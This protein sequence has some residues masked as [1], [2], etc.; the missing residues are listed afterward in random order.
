RKSSPDSGAFKWETARQAVLESMRLAL[1]VDS[2]RLWRQGIPDRS[3]MSLFLRLSCKMLELPETSR[4][5]SRQAELA[6]QL[7]AKPFHLV[8]GMETEVTA[9]VFLLVRECKHLADFVA[10]LCWRL[11][12][13]HGD[14]RLGAEL[15]RE[16]GRME[17]PDINRCGV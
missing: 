16:V 14:S 1:T 4:G 10:R 15:A 7:I 6:S 17:M 8:Q 2:S 5:G 3:F 11:V 13:R 12:D 9:A